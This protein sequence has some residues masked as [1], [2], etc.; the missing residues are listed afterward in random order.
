MKSWIDHIALAGAFTALALTSTLSFADYPER[1]ITLVVPNAP[2]GPTDAI[3]R[4]IGL[5]L[6]ARLGQPVVIDNRGGAGGTIGAETVARAKPDGYTLYLSTTGTL[7]INPALYEKLRYDA[8]KDFDPIGLISTTSNVLM[9]RTDLPAKD[10]KELIALAK[11][12]PGKLTYGSSGSGSSNHLAMELF[13][14]M[15][16]V[17]ITHIP[18]KAISPLRVDIY[19][20][21]IDMVFGVEGTAYKDFGQTGKTRVVMISGKNRSSL[22]PEVPTAEEAGLKGYEMTIWFGL[23]APAGTPAAAVE[24]LNKE[25]NAILATPEMKKELASDGQVPRPMTPQQY[26]AFLNQERQKW[27]PVVKASGAKVE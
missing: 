20:G 15:A 13:K 25:L 14:T 27:L 18:Y 19:E 22:F 12:E 3:A 10:V 8:A 17:Q 6:S 23:N 24:R 1:P 2:G 11:R 26:G 4:S 16:G 9:V 5:K 21:R 7:A